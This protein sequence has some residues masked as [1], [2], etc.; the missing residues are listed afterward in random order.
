MIK[1]RKFIVRIDIAIM[2]NYITKTYLTLHITIISNFSLCL[3]IINDIL[4]LLN[5][6]EGGFMESLGG[7]YLTFILNNETYGIPIKKVKEIIGIMEITHIPKTKGY[8]KGI[9]NLRG[10]I[11]PV[12]DLRIK[13]GMEEKLYTDRT[14]IIVIEV[15]ADKNQ[16]LAGI[17]VDTV[18]EVINIQKDEIIEPKPDTQIKGNYLTGIGELKDKVVLIIDIEKVFSQEEIVVIK[19][20]KTVLEKDAT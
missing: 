18:A 9:I 11:I 3:Y 2:K 4:I 13:F 20:E 5:I 15:N 12:T 16:R 14:S 8:L 7:K 10:K 6:E 17:I 1:C 19:G